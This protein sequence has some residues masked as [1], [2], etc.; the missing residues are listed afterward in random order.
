MSKTFSFVSCSYTELCCE[1]ERAPACCV[2]SWPQFATG[3]ASTL[4]SAERKSRS[5]DTHGKRTTKGKSDSEAATAGL[6]YC[7][8]SQRVR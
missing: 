1:A 3:D 8:T 4:G 2:G 5:G 6:R 7:S